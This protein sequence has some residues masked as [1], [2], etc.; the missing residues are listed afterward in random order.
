MELWPIR[1]RIQGL[2]SEGAIARD[3]GAA[4]W[5][6]VRQLDWSDSPLGLS[7]EGDRS[8]GIPPN[9]GMALARRQD[10]LPASPPSM[11]GYGE[12]MAAKDVD[13]TT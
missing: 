8:I 6:G 4:R 11:K 13:R 2:E 3:G 9:S 10:A 12:L 5:R 7:L 1:R